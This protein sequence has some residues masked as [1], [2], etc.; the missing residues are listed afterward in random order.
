MRFFVDFKKYYNYAVYAARAQLKS[1]VAN[2]YLDWVWWILEP[3][4]FMIIYSIIFGV[5]FDTAEPY[6]PIF[7]FIGNAMWTFFCN[8]ISASVRLVKENQTTVSKVY[9]PKFIL[10]LINMMVNGYKMLL[11]FGIVIVMLF[12]FQVPISWRVILVIPL[13]LIFLMFTFGCGTI[14]MHVGVYVDDLSY[15]VAILLNM[16]MFFTGIFYSVETRIEAPYGYILGNFNP[17]AFLMTAMRKVIMY[18]QTPSLLGMGIWFLIS[19]LIIIAGVKLIYKNEN[20][21]VKV[22]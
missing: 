6:F 11:S 12:F 7:I 17:V 1:E 3:F 19:A 14:F 10:L 8:V 18:S 16:M 5:V 13:F 21:Y 4:C 15:V 22:I 9:I 20:S 2:S